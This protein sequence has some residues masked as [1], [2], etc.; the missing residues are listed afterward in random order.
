MTL[1][2][3]YFTMFYTLY[4]FL[5]AYIQAYSLLHVDI[6]KSDF[7]HT[8]HG[9]AYNTATLYSLCSYSPDLNGGL[10]M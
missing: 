6:Q 3:M 8:P 2:K 7:K 5:S 9:L 4:T 1:K 10:N